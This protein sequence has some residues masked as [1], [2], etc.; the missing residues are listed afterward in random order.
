MESY[1]ERELQAVHCQRRIHRA[2]SPELV[3]QKAREFL[4]D[5]QR[6]QHRG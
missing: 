6:L 1:R 4:V 5:A 2:P 3:L